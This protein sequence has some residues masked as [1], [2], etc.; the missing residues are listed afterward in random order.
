MNIKRQEIGDERNLSFE[1]ADG[2]QQS[3]KPGIEIGKGRAFKETQ[4]HKEA[5]EVH[6]CFPRSRKKDIPKKSLAERIQK[7]ING[8]K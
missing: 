6:H 2:K 1:I 3:L 8:G 7:S 5:G 4:V